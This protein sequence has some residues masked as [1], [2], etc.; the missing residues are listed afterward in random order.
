[1]KKRKRHFFALKW[2]D[3]GIVF[4]SRDWYTKMYRAWWG[5]DSVNYV[6]QA[7]IVLYWEKEWVDVYKKFNEALVTVSDPINI[8]ETIGR[9]GVLTLYPNNKNKL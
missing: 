8:Q 9:I 3:W 6:L 1:M 5:R 7:C 2:E 4:E